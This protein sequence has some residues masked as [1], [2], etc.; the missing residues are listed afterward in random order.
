MWESCHRAQRTAQRGSQNA[1][2]LRTGTLS[3]GASYAARSIEERSVSV[4]A[5]GNT[6][7]RDSG[8]E[9]IQKSSVLGRA[10]ASG[11]IKAMSQQIP[12]FSKSNTE[13]LVSGSQ[14]VCHWIDLEYLADCRSID[15]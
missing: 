2:P 4:S 14:S 1:V 8:Q 12:S 3:Q 7:I 10:G 13:P 6:V 9:A 5:R 11:P 15:S